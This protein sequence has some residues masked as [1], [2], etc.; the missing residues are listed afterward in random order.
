MRLRPKSK[1]KTVRAWDRAARPWSGMSCRVL[2]ARIVEAEEL[3]RR[4]QALLRRR[5]EEDAVA[6]FHRQPGV[7]RELV[8]E[9]PR[10]PA[11]VAQGD[12]HPARAFA[13]ADRLK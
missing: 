12:Q 2:Q 6:R 13:A 4:R 10:R 9:L 8:L 7:L 3:H 11:G 1:A 5:L